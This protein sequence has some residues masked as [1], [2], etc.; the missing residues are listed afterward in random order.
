MQ[1]ALPDAL[2][3]HDNGPFTG[4][5]GIPDSTEGSAI[6]GPG[7]VQWS[8]LIM[9]ANHSVSDNVDRESIILDGETTRLEL[10][11]R[12]GIAPGFELGVEIPYL[13]H[14]SGGFDSFIDNWHN[15]LGFSGGFRDSRSRGQLEYK[16]TDGN[17]TQIDYRKNEKGLGDLRLFSGWRLQDN[18]EHSMALRFGVKLPTGDSESLLGS[19]GTDISIGLAGDL[20][21]LFGVA[22]LT[23]HYRASAIRIGEPDLLADRYRDFVGYFGLGAGYAVTENFELLAQAAVRTPLYDSDIATLGDS[24]GTL[25]LG[26]N[27]RVFSNYV[28]GV[29][30]SED[31]KVL[32]APDVAFQLSIKYQSR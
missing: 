25:T 20:R 16:Y 12:R 24:A 27:F 10:S 26:G 29:G 14:E 11:F 31:I 13:W 32:S 9:T 6:L 18:P 4:Y 23:A 3:D 28:I 8:S 2:H 30:V 5:F 17:A 1:S 19:G 21:G 7:V 22:G 15:W